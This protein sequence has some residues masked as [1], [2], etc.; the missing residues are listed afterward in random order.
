MHNC[1]MLKLEQIEK[2]LS[3]NYLFSYNIN[4]IS[5][6]NLNVYK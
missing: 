3:D 6:Q 5:E 4:G 2:T 1:Y